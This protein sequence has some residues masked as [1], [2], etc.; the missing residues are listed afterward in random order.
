MFDSDRVASIEVNIAR[1]AR[2][3]GLVVALASLPSWRAVAETGASRPRQDTLAQTGA[4]SALGQRFLRIEPSFWDTFGITLSRNGQR[5]GPGFFSMIPDEVVRGSPEAK[6]HAGHARVYQGFVIGFGVAGLGLIGTGVAE[7][8]SA[9]EW[10]TGAKVLVASGVVGVLVQYAAALA[11]QNEIAAAVSSYNE[12][13]VRA[14]F[15]E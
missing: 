6:R 8:A 1:R 11:R 15:A 5:V 3:V 10:N 2:S 9:S 13:L 4:P 7:R 14:T 12:D